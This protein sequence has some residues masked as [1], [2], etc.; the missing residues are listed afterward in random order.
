MIALDGVSK[1]YRSPF[2][3]TT[4]ALS[5]LDLRASAGEVV[6]VA[7]PNGAGKSTLIGLLLGFLAPTDGSL[8]IEGLPPRR[9]I[10]RHGVGYVPEA[11]VIPPR[12][13]LEAAVLRYA[14][15][16]DV[17]AAERPARRD[18]AIARLGLEEHRRKRIRHLSKGTRQR[19]ALA[20]A[21]VRRERLYVF[22]E[23]AG[24]LDPLWTIA[25]RETV[26]ALRAPDVLVLIASHDL[27]ELER[28]AD[29]VLILH[30]G[31]LRGEVHLGE[32]GRDGSRLRLV[33][34]AGAALV[35]EIIVG[36]RQIAA[37]AF[38]VPAGD[39][40][41]LNAALAALIARGGRI[42]SLESLRST[43]EQSFRD[44]VREEPPR[45]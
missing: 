10:E 6:G 27:D 8:T 15:L 36:A 1:R 43:L 20:Q 30:H 38:E 9:W 40:E 34:H 19:T 31:R 4:A 25:F 37:D 45:E 33:M 5:D 11:P 39:P 24:G 14:T 13:T 16:A 2:G 44:L 35:P 3:R 41:A 12:W 17:P 7:G 23:P 22:D 26:A 21:L 42:A 29:R 32:R 28:T 18:A